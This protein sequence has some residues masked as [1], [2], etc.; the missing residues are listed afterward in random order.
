M[1]P[2]DGECPA[3]RGVLGQEPRIAAGKLLITRPRVAG[4]VGVVLQYCELV[5]RHFPSVASCGL[6]WTTGNDHG[7]GTIA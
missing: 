3:P 4:Y 7:L 5:R 1:G 6:D 2:C